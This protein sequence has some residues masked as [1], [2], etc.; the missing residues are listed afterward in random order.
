MRRRELITLGACN[1][2]PESNR[3]RSSLNLG[4]AMR[5]REFISFVGGVV[6]APFGAHAQQSTVP[7]IGFLRPGPPEASTNMLAAFRKGL[8]ETGFVEGRNLAIEFRW[9]GPNRRLI[10]FDAKLTSSSRRV[11]L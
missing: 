5:R 1:C 3:R 9:R 2:L 4:E 10:W 7:V 8:S 11:P 6:V